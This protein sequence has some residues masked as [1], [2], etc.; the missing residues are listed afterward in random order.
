MK[1]AFG[2]QH[3]QY[4]SMDDNVEAL[5]LRYKAAFAEYQ[6][7][8]NKHA[9]L[10][11]SGGKPSEQALL[12]EERAFEELDVARYALLDAA[13]LAYPTIH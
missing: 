1:A 11:M 3:E 10:C 8:M 4:A 2:G 7:L 9:E 13:A 6:G 12:E 5:T